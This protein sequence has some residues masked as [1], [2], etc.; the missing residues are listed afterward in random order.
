MNN[1]HLYL[2]ALLPPAEVTNQINNVKQ[3][4]SEKYLC[5]KALRTLPHLTLIPPI[6]ADAYFETHLLSL[7]HWITQQQAFAISLR[8]FSFFKNP[9]HPVVFI[10]VL[11]N[12]QLNELYA[13]LRKQLKRYL[14]VAAETPPF[15]PHFTVGYRDIPPQKFPEIMKDYAMQRFQ[16]DF[17]IKAVYLLKH[18][19]REWKVFHEFPMGTI[20]KETLGHQGSL[21]DL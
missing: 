19:T 1:Q 5:Y 15:H 18:N 2:I 11:K 7:E 17:D 14:P 3:A 4:F 6:Q 9:Q 21:F 12:A 16:A 8:N 20:P 13:G 10:D